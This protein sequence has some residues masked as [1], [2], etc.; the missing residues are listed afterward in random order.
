MKECLIR[1]APLLVQYNGLTKP[2]FAPIQCIWIVLKSYI[3]LCLNREERRKTVQRAMK[4]PTGTAS[5]KYGHVAII[6]KVSENKIEIIQQ[7]P[8]AFTKSRKTI[9]LDKTNGAWKIKNKR[10][11]GWLRKD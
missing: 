9:S 11:L 3:S 10:I 5:N 6:S 2:I 4:T 8:G 7:N 1:C